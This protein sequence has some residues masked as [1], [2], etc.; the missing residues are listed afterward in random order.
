MRKKLRCSIIHRSLVNARSLRVPASCSDFAQFILVPCDSQCN[1][2]LASLV[3]LIVAKKHRTHCFPCIRGRRENWQKA[4]ALLP[5]AAR[6]GRSRTP[7]LSLRLCGFFDTRKIDQ[8]RIPRADRYG[9]LLRYFPP[10]VRPRRADPIG[11]WTVRRQR[12]RI[13]KPI[14][15]R[16]RHQRP[17]E[18][19]LRVHVRQHHA[20]LSVIRPRRLEVSRPD[21]IGEMIAGGKGGR[22][23]TRRVDERR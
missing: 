8:G 21:G 20:H 3:K 7:C 2:V 15:A 4:H 13:V 19:H 16:R 11:T 10:L 23:P 18:P 22:I 6:T 1:R 5:R 12:R 9:L 14:H 17:V